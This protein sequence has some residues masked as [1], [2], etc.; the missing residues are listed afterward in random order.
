MIVNGLHGGIGGSNS[1]WE[2]DMEDKDKEL[3]QMLQ[4]TL[5][6]LFSPY[7]DQA[8]MYADQAA[9]AHASAD[10]CAR[11]AVEARDEVREMIKQSKG[12]P[13]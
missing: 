5:D 12:E 3:L 2:T 6:R 11:E 9:A 13:K 4:S 7:L 1:K 10:S 8:K